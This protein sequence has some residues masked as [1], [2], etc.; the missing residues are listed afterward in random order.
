MPTMP[1][2]TNKQKILYLFSRKTSYQLAIGR[3]TTCHQGPT[4]ERL[5]PLTKQSTFFRFPIPPAR[6]SYRRLVTHLVHCKIS[7]AFY[8][9][10]PLSGPLVYLLSMGL[11]YRRHISIPIK[12]QVVVMQGA[13][14]LPKCGVA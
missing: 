3:N 1:G 4:V 14:L 11:G 13:H 2:A 5:Q 10:V 8:R 6:S 7:N 12:E 9:I